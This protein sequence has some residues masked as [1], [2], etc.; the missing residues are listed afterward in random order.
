MWETI[1]E[2][3]PTADKGVDEL[4]RINISFVFPPI[5]ETMASRGYDAPGSMPFLV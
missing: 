4:Q 2:S 3:H 5:D 1:N